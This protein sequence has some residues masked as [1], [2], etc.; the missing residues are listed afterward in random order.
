MY[1]YID[2]KFLLLLDIYN[3]SGPL[4]SETQLKVI[5]KGCQLKISHVL[6]DGQ[7]VISFTFTQAN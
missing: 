1:M 6:K 4:F 2:I 5:G 7:P 3:D